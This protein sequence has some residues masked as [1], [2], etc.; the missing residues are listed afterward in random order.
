MTAHGDSESQP[1]ISCCKSPHPITKSGL[2][3]WAPFG[4]LG[5]V[6][7]P[8]RNVGYTT[9]GPQSSGRPTILCP[10]MEKPTTK[11]LYLLLGHLSSWPSYPLSSLPP[12]FR[13]R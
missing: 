11:H 9:P 13:A 1:G 3:V 4:G 6:N 8:E 10:E 12:T 5:S 2:L 7:C